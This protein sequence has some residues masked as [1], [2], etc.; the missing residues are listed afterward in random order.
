MENSIKNKNLEKEKIEK[1]MKNKKIEKEKL[2]EYSIKFKKLE[3][4]RVDKY[5]KLGVC[6]NNNVL[7]YIFI[8]NSLIMKKQ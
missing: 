3:K 7:K 5:K 1:S 8:L 4:E 2:E 6:Y